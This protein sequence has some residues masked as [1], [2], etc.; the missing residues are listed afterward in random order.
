MNIVEALKRMWKRFFGENFDKF[1]VLYINGS[2]TLPPPL[3]SMEE[4]EV[5]ARIDEDDG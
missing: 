4:S 3:S 1:P 5:L 2:Q